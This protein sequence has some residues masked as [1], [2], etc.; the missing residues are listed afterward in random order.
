MKLL[1]AALLA[2]ASVF[3]TDSPRRGDTLRSDMTLDNT[4]RHND[5]AR[6]QLWQALRAVGVN[7]E[8]LLFSLRSVREDAP[9]PYMNVAVTKMDAQGF[10]SP[11][12]SDIADQ[13]LHWLQGDSATSPEVE[14]AGDTLSESDEDAPIATTSASKPVTTSSV[15]SL[16]RKISEIRSKSRGQ[17]SSKRVSSST[18][19]KASRDM[20]QQHMNAAS[21]IVGDWRTMGMWQW[22]PV[23]NSFS[24]IFALQLPHWTLPAPLL[25]VTGASKFRFVNGEDLRVGQGDSPPREKPGTVRYNDEGVRFVLTAI[26]THALSTPVTTDV[27][28]EQGLSWPELVLDSAFGQ[29]VNTQTPTANRQLSKALLGMV[30]GVDFFNDCAA[31]V[32]QALFAPAAKLVDTTLESATSHA[33]FAEVSIQGISVLVVKLKQVDA[34]SSRT[35]TFVNPSQVDD[36]FE[37]T[38]EEPDVAKVNFRVGEQLFLAMQRNE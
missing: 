12:G 17:S 31:H 9:T 37:S 16:A 3:G 32:L 27:G 8:K 19:Q 24:L 6:V 23:D 4:M 22:Q 20:R 21:G 11:A 36:L 30:T 7:R 14:Y 33:H 18:L 1:A 26:F 5:V 25:E 10:M 13:F 15:R 35:K 34:A 28:T 2:L 38:T 29:T